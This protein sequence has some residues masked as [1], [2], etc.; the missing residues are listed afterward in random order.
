MFYN[1]LCLLLIATGCLCACKRELAPEPCTDV[2]NP[3]CVNYDP[4][5]GVQSVTADFEMWAFDPVLAAQ[6]PGYLKDAFIS[7]DSIFQPTAVYFRAKLKGASY[8]WQLG[9]EMVTDSGDYRY[10]DASGNPGIYRVYNNSLT[11][12]KNPN[13]SCFPNDTNWATKS[14]SLKIVRPSQLLTSGTFRVKYEGMRD[15]VTLQILTWNSFEGTNK[16][17]SCTYCRLLLG[18]R[19]AVEDSNYV[20]NGYYT[21]KIIKFQSNPSMDPYNGYFKVD[22]SSQAVLAEYDQEVDVNGVSITKHY[23]CRGRKIK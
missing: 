7:E 10:F 4:C 3:N 19:D 13:Y 11:V 16:D 1:V 20:Y 17:T 22:P 15:S 5:Y 18:F 9:T 21:N 8:V 12:T 2:T 23:K 14:R 6:G